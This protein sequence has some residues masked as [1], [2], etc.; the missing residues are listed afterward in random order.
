MEMPERAQERFLNNV[1]G[2]SF[3]SRQPARKLVRCIEM[4]QDRFLKNVN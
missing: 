4:W 3:V 2:I 1:F